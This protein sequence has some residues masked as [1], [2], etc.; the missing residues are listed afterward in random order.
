[1]RIPSLKEVVSAQEWQLRVD[2]AAAYR[3]V[4]AYGMSDLVF[5][6]V[7]ARI[8]GPEHQFLINPYGMM[9]DEPANPARRC[10]GRQSRQRGT[11]CHANLA[12][13]AAKTGPHGP[14]LQELTTRCFRYGRPGAN[15]TR[16]PTCTKATGQAL[17]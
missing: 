4:A 3:L 1:M 2:L 7:S 11:G 6:H 12:R 5:T 13:A 10:C 17:T 16:E 9:F 14:G 15:P 8:L